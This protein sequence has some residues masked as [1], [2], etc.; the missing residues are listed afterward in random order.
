MNLQNG[1]NI[2]VNTV[3][4]TPLTKQE[5]VNV[6]EALQVVVQELNAY[7]MLQ[8]KVK[9]ESEIKKPEIKQPPEIKE[10]EGD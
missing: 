8:K 5:R 9:A 2:I 10:P 4:I 3:A 6:E 1:F 7:D